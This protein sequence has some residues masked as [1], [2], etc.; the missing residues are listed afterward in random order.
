MS[1]LL[2]AFFLELDEEESEMKHTKGGNGK[3]TSLSI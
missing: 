3:E 2:F 1:V